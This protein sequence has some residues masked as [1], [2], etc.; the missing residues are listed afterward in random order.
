MSDYGSKGEITNRLDKED[1]KSRDF[2]E[3]NDNEA[4]GLWH[5]GVAI[6]FVKELFGHDTL[7]VRATP[8]SESAVTMEFDISGTEVAATPLREACN[9]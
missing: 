2:T 9:W 5:G 4:L 8:Y 6:P 3:S 7:L 1:A